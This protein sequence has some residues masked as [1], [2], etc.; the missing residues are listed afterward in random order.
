[1]AEVAEGSRLV[2]GIDFGTTYVICIPSTS[3]LILQILI[4]VYRFSG[5]AFQVQTD[6]RG[7]GQVRV[8]LNWPCPVGHARDAD[9][10]KVPSKLSYPKDYDSDDYLSYDDDESD[11]NSILWGYQVVEDT[12]TTIEW[13]KLLLL[14]NTDLPD[15][16]RHSSKLRIARQRMEAMG[17]TPV[18]L[19][20]DY[21]EKL[22]I[23]AMGHDEKPGFI[24]GCLPFDP[25]KFPIHVVI[26]V[27]AIWKQNAQN[28]TE[29][30]LK[31]AILG[32]SS[33]S[34]EVTT[35][36]QAAIMAHAEEIRG[37]MKINDIVLCL[38]LGGGTADCISY[39]LTDSKTL[40]L[41]E[42]VPGDGKL[43]PSVYKSPRSPPANESNPPYIV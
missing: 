4:S 39:R 6:G 41:V 16:L 21:L 31:R 19:V 30:A 7:V 37:L 20:A 10:A 25:R 13:P 42:V 27:P 34:F 3:P 15:H 29:E 24:A 2:V 8:V 36:P 5:V 32:T 38:D 43:T 1:M 35:E 9:E 12:E 28:L 11:E 14:D 33:I 26:T 23:H 18:D 40:D 17:K 22:W